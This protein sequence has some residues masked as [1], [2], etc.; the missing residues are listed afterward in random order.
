MLRYAR[1]CTIKL[2]SDLRVTVG[3]C[4]CVPVCVRACERERSEASEASAIKALH[5][6]HKVLSAHS[7][8]LCG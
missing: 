7:R 2:S 1:V 6:A 3:V 4:V 8:K 5:L